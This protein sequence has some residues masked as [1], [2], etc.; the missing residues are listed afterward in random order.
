MDL[1]GVE[2]IAFNALGGADTITVNDL[3]GTGVTQVDVNLAANGGA[4]DGAADTVI[5]DGTN[6]ANTIEVFGSGTSFSVVGLPGLSMSRARRAR[7][8]RS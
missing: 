2:K 3:S 4:G 6:G 7:T 8:T 1:N 5:V